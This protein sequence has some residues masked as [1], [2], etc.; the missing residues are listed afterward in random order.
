MTPTEIELRDRLQRLA[1]YARTEPPDRLEPLAGEERRRPRH[2]WTAAVAAGLLIGVAVTGVALSR[3]GG[4]S[5]TEGGLATQR[6]ADAGL[7]GRSGPSSVWTGRELLVWGGLTSENR[8]L[9]DGAAL[10]PVANRW[11]ALPPA[12][13]GPRAYAP[14][15]W[16]G[17]EMLVWGGV[18]DGGSAAVD[19][20]AYD[21]RTN[22]WRAI[23]SQP[24]GGA[25]PSAFVWTGSEMVVVSA[26]NGLN[27]TAY[28]PAT[29][30]WRRLADPPGA[31]LM[32]Y[33]EAVWTGSQIVLV[34][35]PSGG[36]G[37]GFGSSD[38]PPSPT[39]VVERPSTTGPAT[40]LPPPP[41][42]PLP[43]L[44]AVGGPN[45]G[46]FVAA[47]TPGSDQWSR[48]P[49]VDLKDGSLPRVVWTGSEVLVLQASSPGAA[50]SPA[51]GAWRRLAPLPADYL[52]E[53]PAVWTGRSGLLWAGG[54]AGWAYDAGADA[55]STFDAGGLPARSDPVVA[56]ADGVLVGW[57]GF[58]RVDAGAG[59]QATD[60]VLYRPPA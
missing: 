54:Q 17:T 38:P 24:F 46:M 4:P 2:T 25:G 41:P 49:A 35:W 28:N 33:P 36:R 12:P 39:S 58:Y 40:T 20:A 42:P 21:P 19:G 10:D 50:Y 47:Y 34:M 37:F 3:R 45:S 52:P 60:G 29:D 18:V 22:R 57:G 14:A 55:W 13:I 44:P 15:V 53:A 31:P 32:P 26:L 1:E 6:L 30:R 27:T 51:R 5:P 11:R 48:L 9:A 16:T 7:P 56:W 43:V 59:R 23:A 8:R